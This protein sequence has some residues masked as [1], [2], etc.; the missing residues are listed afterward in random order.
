MIRFDYIFCPYVI[1]FHLMVVSTIGERSSVVGVAVADVVVSD[2]GG[3]GVGDG[4]GRDEG[5]LRDGD[6][7][8]GVLDDGRVDVVGGLEHGGEV[9]GGGRGE[10]GPEPVLVGDVVVG[11]D[12]AVGQRVAVVN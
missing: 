6:V 10:V 12:A 2:G 11:Q 3:G 5:R 1:Y 8:D 7:A 4:L 9:L